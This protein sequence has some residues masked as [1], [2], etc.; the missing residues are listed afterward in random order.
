MGLHWEGQVCDITFSV[1][2]VRFFVGDTL[3]FNLCFRVDSK[4]NL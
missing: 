4:I 2:L 3:S 1:A